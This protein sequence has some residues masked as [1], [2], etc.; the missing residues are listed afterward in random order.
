MR[1]A[2][3]LRTFN[4]G[5]GMIAIVAPDKVASVAEILRS[6]GE[7]VAVLGEVIAARGDE[8]VVYDNTLDLS[9]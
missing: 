8:R 3:M 2:E 9:Q 1:R 5:I 6:E 4:C 7:T